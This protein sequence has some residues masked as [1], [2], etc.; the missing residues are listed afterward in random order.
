MPR[1]ISIC[2]IEDCET[3][4]EGHG[5]C[6]K[7]YQRW[8]KYGDPMGNPGRTG[9]PRGDKCGYHAAHYRIRID[10]GHASEYVCACGSTARHWALRWDKAGVEIL[11]DYEKGKRGE[12]I[13]YSTD[14]FAYEPMCRSC[15]RYFDNSRR[16]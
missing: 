1:P 2:S 14:P 4:V 11:I 12:D 13:E 7:H 15:H 6:S 8:K 16:D 10:R 5:Y 9:R 3:R